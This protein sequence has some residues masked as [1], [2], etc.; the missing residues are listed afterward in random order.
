MR[1]ILTKMFIANRYLK[2]T[3]NN[4][5]PSI[6]VFLSFLA[7]FLSVCTLIIVISVFNGFKQEFVRIVVGIKAPVVVYARGGM[8]DYKAVL[9]DVS[10]IS[11]V[12]YAYP[13][14][15]GQGMGMDLE[16][17]SSVGVVL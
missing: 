3:K 7:M 5:F 9:E 13:V 6:G 11:G 1:K 16:G 8:G 2:S 17:G 4:K 14:I 10:D 12:K 15:N